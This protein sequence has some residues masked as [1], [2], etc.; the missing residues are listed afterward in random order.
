MLKSCEGSEK[1][2]MKWDRLVN[3]ISPLADKSVLDVGC[4]NGYH[5]WRML[6]H[7]PEILIG[8]DPSPRFSIQFEMIKRMAGR[9]LPIHLVPAP[10]EVIPRP[11][12]AFDT[13]FSMGVIYHR[14]DPLEHLQQLDDCLKPGGELIL[15]SLIVD[16]DSA[17]CLIPD[18]RYAKMRNVWMLPSSEM[19]IRWLD[20]EDFE[21]IQLVDES[22]TTTEE[23]RRTEW[24]CFE[25][26]ADFLDPYDSSRT[27]EGYP[28]PK[29]AIISAKK[30]H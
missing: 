7:K 15:E 8:V 6:E 10:L 3:H 9:N 14:K 1:S 16:G 11:T 29:R 12:H 24:M 23:Q 27:I 26:L 4:G 13:V 18:H 2:D 17:T 19:M 20:A 22:I 21:N 25:S 28:A 30:R 5:M